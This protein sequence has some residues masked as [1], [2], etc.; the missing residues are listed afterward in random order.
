MASR[1]LVV[2][3]G[4]AVMFLAAFACQRGESTQPRTLMLMDDDSR[5]ARAAA[6][7]KPAVIPDEPRPAEWGGT[8]TPRG[9]IVDTDSRP[10]TPTPSKQAPI[11]QEP[12]REQ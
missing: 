3:C 7:A 8:D 9:M 2:L 4:I 11:P 12:R 10:S 6:A 5:E 1:T